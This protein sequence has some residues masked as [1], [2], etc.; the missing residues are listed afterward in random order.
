MK[1]YIFNTTNENIDVEELDK[2]IKFACNHLKIEN[3]LLNIVIVDNKKIQEINRE[4]RNKDA[5]T[6]VISFAF[7]EVDDVNYEDFR[8]LGEI[9]ISYE[10]CVSQAS[11]YG[12]SVKREFCYLAVHGLLH[13]LGYDHMVDEDKKIMRALEEE[14]LN[15]YDI[16]R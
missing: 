11:D 1:D 3:P 2:V 5:V 10:R 13:L 9:Y 16:K 6:D 15:E 14:I 7:E 4:Y 8:F 12:H